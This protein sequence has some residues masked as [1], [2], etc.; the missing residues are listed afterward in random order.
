MDSPSF[1]TVMRFQPMIPDI[2]PILVTEALNSASA[3]DIPLPTNDTARKGIGAGLIIFI[4]I[5][6]FFLIAKKR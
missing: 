3:G 2:Q 6:I 4:G 5:V 1:E